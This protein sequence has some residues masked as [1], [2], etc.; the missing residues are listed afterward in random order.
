MTVSLG[1]YEKTIR[2]HGTVEPQYLLLCR[3]KPPYVITE[4]IVPWNKRTQPIGALCGLF[5]GSEEGKLMSEVE[6]LPNF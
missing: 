3:T 6:V 4:R 2:V 1:L 5:V